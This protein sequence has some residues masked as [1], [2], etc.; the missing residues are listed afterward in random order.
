MFYVAVICNT[1]CMSTNHAT[2]DRSRFAFDLA[3]RMRRTLR[4]SGASAQEM[5]D[6]LDVSRT[7]VSN[8]IN[9]RV[10]P[11]RQ[12]LRLWALATGFPYKWLETGEEP[13]PGWQPPTE[14]PEGIEP[15]TY[16][17][18][19]RDFSSTSATILRQAS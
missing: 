11:G 1:D 15:S 6:Y 10:T 5:A 16:S 8:W 9:G 17:L 3:D 7:S 18:Q 2:S 12:T 13:D 4:V 19:G 14:P